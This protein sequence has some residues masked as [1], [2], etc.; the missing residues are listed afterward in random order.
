MDAIAGLQVRDVEQGGLWATQLAHFRIAVV[1]W[2]SIALPEITFFGKRPS[3]LVCD[4][5]AVL[6]F[7][8]LELRQVEGIVLQLHSW[9]WLK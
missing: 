4:R 2:Q 6:G 5:L 3:V 8:T 9:P 7:P 1:G